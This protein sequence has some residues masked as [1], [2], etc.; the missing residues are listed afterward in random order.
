MLLLFDRNAAAHVGLSYSTTSD[1]AGEIEGAV[2]GWPSCGILMY[3]FSELESVNC[4][5]QIR[6]PRRYF[7]DTPGESVRLV[8]GKRGRDMEG[9]RESHEITGSP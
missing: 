2:D 7:S 9:T 1:N 4:V 3:R 5:I 8:S 6:G